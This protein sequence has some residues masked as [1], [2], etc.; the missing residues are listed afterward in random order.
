MSWNW[1]RVAWTKV[2]MTTMTT[3]SFALS[4]LFLLITIP[5]SN[6]T[7]PISAAS[8]SNGTA[9]KNVQMDRLPPPDREKRDHED[10]DTHV[11]GVQGDGAP[12]PPE[13]ATT[14]QRVTESD[15][16]GASTVT[17]S[18]RQL[19]DGKMAENYDGDGE[20]INGRHEK[21]GLGNE[22]NGGPIRKESLKGEAGECF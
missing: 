21:N 11:G 4:F 13:T 2:K 14:R 17:N 20:K 5:S 22:I 1:R 19:T 15:G 8:S 18:G 9:N 16:N 10:Y 12:P 3:T 7:K 6:S